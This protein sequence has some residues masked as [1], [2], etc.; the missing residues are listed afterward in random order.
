MFQ[1]GYKNALTAPH[2]LELIQLAL[3]NARES[4]EPSIS[5]AL[6]EYVD[7]VL[8]QMKKTVKRPSASTATRTIDQNQQVLQ[9]AIAQAYLDHADLVADL[10]HADI[11]KES[12][13]KAEKWGGPG[14]NKKNVLASATN[15]KKARVDIATVSDSIFPD[16]VPPPSLPWKFP[17]PDT[18]LTDTPQ[19]VSCLGL[20]NQGSSA[21]NET[22]LGPLAY[23]WLTETERDEEEKARLEA[24]ATNLIRAFKQDKMKDGKAIAEVL[25]LVPVLG[26]DDV[27]FLLRI[28]LNNFEAYHILDIGALRGLAQLLQSATPGHLHAQDLIEI[29]RPISALLQETHAQSQDHIFELTFAVSSVLDAMA[30][31]KVTGLDRAELHEPLLV[32]L[33]DLQGTENPHLKYYAAYAFQALL[34]V[35]AMPSYAVLAS[36]Q[37]SWTPSNPSWILCSP[38]KNAFRSMPLTAL[39]S[40]EMPLTILVVRRTVALFTKASKI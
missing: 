12:R 13:R 21:L 29:L 39:T 31:T 1:S 33:R 23:K 3:R 15:N 34:C 30:F 8:G 25:C 18:P 10:D 40:P 24:L 20:L 6:C 22:S 26:E 16:D 17:E 5:L 37:I 2:A 27:R 9:Q 35:P 32:F 28:F 38:D 7:T 14:S 11:A 36:P 4:K 19:L